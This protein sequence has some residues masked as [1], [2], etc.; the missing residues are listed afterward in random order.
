MARSLQFAATMAATVMA[1]FLAVV[2]T[3]AIAAKVSIAGEVTYTEKVRLPAD[4][5][6]EIALVDLASPDVPR[7]AASAAIAERGKI[8]LSFTLGFDD[9]V[10]LAGHSY[11]MTASITSG[12]DVWFRTLTP[13]PVDP[14]HPAGPVEIVASFAGVIQKPAAAEPA[15]PVSTG[16]IGVTWQADTIGGAP[17]AGTGHP[18]MSIGEDMRAGGRGGC[19]SWFSEVA[20]GD[21]TLSFSAVAAT[22]MACLS[23]QQTAEEKAFFD[24]LAAT[25][26]WRI[27]EESLILADANGAELATFSKARF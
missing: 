3:P 9:A 21:E 1:I 25:R 20:L 11:G 2:A 8:P 13:L 17:V 16:I 6:L 22:R 23:D 15:A 24:V 18:T 5:T 12:E 10:I 26:F 14:L 19:N 7:V 4:A 27:D